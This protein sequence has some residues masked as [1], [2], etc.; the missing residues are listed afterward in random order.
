MNAPSGFRIESDVSLSS[1]WLPA[2]AFYRTYADRAIAVAVAI[3]AVAIEGVDDP[4]I[5]EVRVVGARSGTV[6]WRSSDEE[7]E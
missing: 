3:E 7:Y 5:Q 4:G 1:D 6:L 2:D